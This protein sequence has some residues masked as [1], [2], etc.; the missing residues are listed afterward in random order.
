M[1]NEILNKKEIIWSGN[2][3]NVNVEVYAPIGSFPEG[4]TLSIVPIKTKKRFK[5]N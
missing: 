4:T 5:W 3:N 1:N 2:Y